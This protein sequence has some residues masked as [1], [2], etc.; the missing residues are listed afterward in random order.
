MVDLLPSEYSR[1][2]ADQCVSVVCINIVHCFLWLYQPVIHKEL[3]RLMWRC[4]KTN[5]K[6]EL[7]FRGYLY[8]V[9]FL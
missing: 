5:K 3:W 4:Q 9:S 7:V 8:V 2:C 1:W 6:S